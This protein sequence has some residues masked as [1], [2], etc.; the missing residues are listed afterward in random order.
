MDFL[1]KLLEIAKK[2]LYLC[3]MKGLTLWEA[4]TCQ[5]LPDYKPLKIKFYV[6]NS[7]INVTDVKAKNDKI[8]NTAITEIK[9]K[10]KA[11]ESVKT[12]KFYDWKSYP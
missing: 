8:V 3:N 4:L 7:G 9:K 6:E 11:D 10:L 5:S 12:I 1:A 2:I